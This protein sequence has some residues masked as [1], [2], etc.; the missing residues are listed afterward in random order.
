MKAY[1]VPRED[2]DNAAFLAGWRAGRLVLQACQDCGRT[3]F[4][5]RPVCPHC[6]SDAIADR[7]ASGRGHIVSYSLVHRPND[8]AFNDEVPIMLAEVALAEGTSLI[9][10]IVECA[11][12]ELRSGLPV[13]LPAAD[14][15]A[16]Y[17]LPVF[18]PS[19]SP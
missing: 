19:A 5:P 1:P 3:F 10:R 13:E 8:P 4:Y 11:P 6:W 18:R 2:A 9:A 12:E 14:V 15:C 16:R 17:P 7:T